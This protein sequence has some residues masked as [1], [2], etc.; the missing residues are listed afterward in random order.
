M[1][2]QDKCSPLHCFTLCKTGHQAAQ[3]CKTSPMQ[4]WRWPSWFGYSSWQYWWACQHCCWKWWYAW[5]LSSISS[6]WGDGERQWLKWWSGWE[7]WQSHWLMPC[8]W[9][10]YTLGQKSWLSFS[11]V[12]NQIFGTWG[13]WAKTTWTAPAAGAAVATGAMVNMLTYSWSCWMRAWSSAIAG[14]FAMAWLLKVI[15]M[16]A[17]SRSYWELVGCN[18]FCGGRFRWSGPK[19]VGPGIQWE[20]R[21]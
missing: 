13:L 10:I 8:N 9:V 6:W 21:Q 4:F 20:R 3:P 11:W 18:K 15:T 14:W 16:F 19:Y 1:I 5:C 12:I 2:L 17:A 7:L